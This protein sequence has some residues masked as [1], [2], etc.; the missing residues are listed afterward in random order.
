MSDQSH[1][2][3][4]TSGKLQAA[5]LEAQSNKSSM[6]DAEKLELNKTE[7]KRCFRPGK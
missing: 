1:W 2:K 3:D 5:E 7:G 6:N 4:Q